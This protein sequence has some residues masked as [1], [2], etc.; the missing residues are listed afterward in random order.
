MKNNKFTLVFASLL[1]LLFAFPLHGQVV[2]FTS[3][4]SPEGLVRIY[5]ALGVPASGR[6][7]VKIST[8]ESSKSNHLRPELIKDLVQKVGGTLVECNTAYGG[9]RST[10]EDH[11]KA[12]EQRGYNEIAP[13]DI[14]DS[15]GTIDLPVTDDK[16]IKFDRVGSHLQNYDFMIN[17]AHFKGHAMGGF[18]GVLKNQS[19][20]V[21]SS[22]GKL[23]IHSAGR[24]TTRW[25]S[26]NQDGFLESMA[27]AAQAVHNYFK[28][29]G[30]DIIYINVMNNMSVDC[31]CDGAPAAP[32][33]KDIGILAS[34][35]P[36]ALD[37]ACLDLVFN[38]K[39]VS[40]DNAKPLQRRINSLHGTHIT[41]YAEQIGLGSRKYTIINID[42]KMENALT[43]RR[44]GLAVI[45]SLEAKGDQ[46]RLETA[47]AEALDKGLTVSEAKEAL[48]QL[49]AYTGF[50]RSLN[51][52]GTLQRVLS[53]R[54][55]SGI[56]DDPGKDADPLSEGYDALKQGTA[57]QTLLSGKSFNYTFVPATDYYLKAHLF[58][59]IFSRNNL[60][61]ADREIVTVSAISALPGCEPQLTAHVAGAMNMGVTE[62]ELRALPALLEEKVG[63]AEAERLR[64][65]LATVLGG[66]Y[67]SVQTV[68]FSV[69]PKGQPNTA[70]AQYFTGN[71][72]L[73][74][75]D[76]GIANVTFEPGCRNNWHIHHKQVQVLICVAGRGW[77]QEWGKPAV[78]LV[79]GVIVEIPEGAKHWH[80]AAAD[81]WMQHLT[82]HKDVQEGASNQW[83][84]P[85]TDEQYA[86][87]NR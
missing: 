14:M 67:K 54:Q 4:I 84:E 26:D 80:G 20:G 39:S 13:V 85:V 18:G 86:I 48:S 66:S 87:V 1:V 77:Y 78:Q 47:L 70:Y 79:P 49:Y 37:Q 82:I 72:Y 36:V 83:L 71:S 3:D 43:P 57:V 65:A 34:T 52:L 35:D 75:M 58:G 27:A 16:W 59:D 64:G 53:H 11:L 32:K 5:E 17:L 12:I 63:E 68:D 19:I 55:E 9:S 29:E 28:Q 6:V 2:Y 24:S 23:Y 40:G 8:G 60:S 74:P 7:A 56:K 31:D 62:S 33:L 73:T 25:M 69:W 61:F 76:G 50:P 41:E 44:Q 30:K 42:S 45:A 38:H 51:A 21:A 46:V 15:E 81:S 22:S 10:T